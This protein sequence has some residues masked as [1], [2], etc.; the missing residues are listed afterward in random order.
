[1][2]SLLSLLYLG[3][4]LSQRVIPWLRHSGI[5]R[6][7]RGSSIAFWMHVGILNAL[8]RSVKELIGAFW[9]KGSEA[10][11]KCHVTARS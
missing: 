11:S 4:C 3:G 5:E 9:P 10:A 7:V 6:I 2:A 1:M 8:L